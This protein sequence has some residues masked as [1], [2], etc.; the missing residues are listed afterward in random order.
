MNKNFFKQFVV[1]LILFLLG[2]LTFNSKLFAAES[3]NVSTASTELN[4]ASL[5]S[6]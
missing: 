5:N 3:L 1:A 6:P 4:S 2:Y